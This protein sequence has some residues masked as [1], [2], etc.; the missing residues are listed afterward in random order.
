MSLGWTAEGTIYSNLQEGIQIQLD[1]RR[2]VVDAKTSRTD[3]DLIYLNS[4]TGWVK[5][6]SGIISTNEE[7]TYEPQDFVLF[8]GTTSQSGSGDNLVKNQKGGLFNSNQQNYNSNSSYN[9]SDQYGYRPM[10]GITDASIKTHGTFGA[11]KKA[12]VNFRV[13]SLEE[14]ETFE[15]LYMLPGYSM[16]LEW[17]HSLILKNEGN[18]T[19]V[20]TLIDYYKKWFRDKPPSDPKAAKHRSTAVLEAV[21]EIRS[22]SNFNY[23]VLFGRASNY[24]WSLTD[25]GSYDCSVDLIGYGE[26]AESLSA[27]FTVSA[28]DEDKN[29]I[30]E[31]TVNTF[32]GYL[33]LILDT[34]P[35]LTPS[36]SLSPIASLEEIIKVKEERGKTEDLEKLQKKADRLK[37]LGINPLTLSIEPPNT[38][39]P[40][41]YKYITFGSFL[42][43]INRHFMLA[44]D[45]IKWVKFYCGKYDT[46][47]DSSEV[48]YENKS[49]FVTFSDHI[50]TN[51]KVCFLPK[52][53]IAVPSSNL[54][55]FEYTFSTSHTVANSIHGDYNDILNIFINVN[56]ISELYTELI[57]KTDVQDTG[58]Y[59]LV[60][61]VLKSVA[62]SLSNINNFSIED[63]DQ[64]KFICDRKGTP[65]YDN[66]TYTWDLFGSKG[67]TRGIT[68]QSV[69]P[70]SLANM[71]AVG[72]AAGGSSLN[73]DIFNFENFYKGYVDGYIEQRTLDKVRKQRSPAEVAEDDKIKIVNA[74]RILNSYLKTVNESKVDPDIDEVDIITAH[75]IVTNLFLKNTL[76]KQ[77]KNPPG[78]IPIELKFDLLGISGIRITDIF[79]VAPG[80][81]PS[82]YKNNVSFVVTGID[83]KI[84][85]SGWVTSITSQ[86]IITGKYLEEEEYDTS[87]VEELIQAGTLLDVGETALDSEILFPN[88]V[89]LRKYIAGYPNL[90]AEKGAELNSSGEDISEKTLKLGRNIIVIANMLLKNPAK[91]ALFMRNNPNDA[92]LNNPQV[93]DFTT[94]DPVSTNLIDNSIENPAGKLYR[95]TAGN[96]RH[97]KKGKHP[98]GNALDI[99]I[100]QTD[101]TQAWI[102]A[103]RL[104]LEV[105]KS[106]QSIVPHKMTPELNLT[107]DG[108]YYPISH[109]GTGKH[110]HWAVI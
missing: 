82:R 110:W 27:I 2:N 50:S 61:K 23:D 17:G 94:L 74:A 107:V 52:P 20:E 79:N 62:K 40:N 19:E 71:I 34:A 93:Y 104:M 63:R 10:G 9:W 32:K 73:E 59:E 70:S 101:S 76:I 13:N 24:S 106:I 35:S 26:V 102:N 39:T 51:L 16:L 7:D 85:S 28:D 95:F 69:I 48:V 103:T 67:L 36:D 98:E 1:K 108:T 31:N 57:K 80:L 11:V 53:V 99:A 47:I 64:V 60:E 38:G 88:A 6:S 68:L 81:L 4:N 77:G 25:E 42:N 33:D 84:D 46:D 15:K 90:F 109:N 12:T 96:D 66:V 45:G 44:D 65:S 100:N 22:G 89:E 83:N 75:R 78:I 29:F 49:P 58:I 37:T 41:S 86:M 72:A 56:L 92:E 43:M 14:L 91:V 5:L 97:H 87:V 21:Q 18:E 8:G 30:G 55:V 105:S 54:R 3:Q